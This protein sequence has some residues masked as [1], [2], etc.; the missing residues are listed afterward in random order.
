MPH[1]FIVDII[2]VHIATNIYNESFLSVTQIPFSTGI[3]LVAL[4]N[5]LV[6]PK[7]PCISLM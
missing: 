5:Y 6:F 4:E 7:A 1:L 2:F 3:H